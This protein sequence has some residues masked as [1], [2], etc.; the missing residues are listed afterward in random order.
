M[1]FSNAGATGA[2]SKATHPSASTTLVRETVNGYLVHLY[3]GYTRSNRFRN[4]VVTVEDLSNI[5][6]TPDVGNR[7][8]PSQYA[9]VNGLVGALQPAQL[10]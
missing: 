10:L 3:T 6:G 1:R 7:T 8:E 5:Y 4:S 9:Y 2:I